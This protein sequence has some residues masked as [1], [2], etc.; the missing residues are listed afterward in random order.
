MFNGGLPLFVQHNVS[1]QSTMFKPFVYKGFERHYFCPK[2][3]TKQGQSTIVAQTIWEG[4]PA[5]K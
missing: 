3:T 4:K 1:V 5:A 2:T